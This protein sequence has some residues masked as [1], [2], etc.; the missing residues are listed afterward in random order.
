MNSREKEY[1]YDEKSLRDL[2]ENTQRCNVNVTGVPEGE[3]KECSD[4]KKLEEIMAESI[5]NL[6]KNI[7]LQQRFNTT[8]KL[9][10]D[11]SKEIHYHTCYNQTAGNYT[12]GRVFKR[13]K[14]KQCIT[15][16]GK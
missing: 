7:N 8:V 5:P 9:K 13:Y 10:Q 3:E 16:G 1:F 11:E 4:E 6:V 14:E 2:W 15:Y 12:Q